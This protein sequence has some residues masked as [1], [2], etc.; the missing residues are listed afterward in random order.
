[1]KYVYMI[2]YLWLEDLPDPLA[3]DQCEC[4]TQDEVLEQ[5][6]FLI[7]KDVEVINVKLVENDNREHEE[8]ISYTFG[9]EVI[10]ILGYKPRY[11]NT[12][13]KGERL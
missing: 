10:Q 2:D 3:V 7:D 12:R 9:Q 4:Y 8:D 13:N 1:M 5:L 11:M 6:K